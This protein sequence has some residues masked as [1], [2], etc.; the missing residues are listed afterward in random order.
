MFTKVLI[1][2]RGEIACRVIRTCKRMGIRTVAVY[3]DADRRSPH[4]VLADEARHLGP[5]P[6]TASYLDMDKILAV[7]GEAK[8][9]AIHPGYGFLSENETFAQR[10]AEAGFVFIGPPPDVIRNMGNKGVA[11][12]FMRLGGIP[13]VPGVDVEVQDGVQAYEIALSLGFPVMVK[14]ME[15]G[16]GI[17][18]NIA[19]TPDGL[20]AALEAAI[21]RA[22]RAFGRS[23]IYLEKYIAGARHIEVQLL[24]DAY[25]N[26]RHLFDRDCSLQRRYQK[27][28]EEAPSPGVTPE[29]RQRIT[30][31][32]VQIGRLAAY[33][34]AG[35]IE[36]LMDRDK[37]YY[38]L[39]MNTRLQVE[40]PVTEGITGVDIVEQQ[41]RVAAGEALSF[42]QKDVKLSGH[43]IECRIYA[44]N[45]RD[46]LPSPGTIVRL[47]EPSG[48]GVRVDSGV[49]EGS[50]VTI[51]YDAMLAKLITWG[52]TRDSALATMRGALDAY[53]IEGVE[54]NIPLLRAVLRH[55]DF[56]A[57]AYDTT[58]LGQF[59]AQPVRS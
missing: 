28:I 20:K 3:S 40:H 5:P 2:N 43:A 42:Q 39:E 37:S 50:E 47:V 41:L 12:R 34:N 33:Q 21:T 55:P 52:P 29:I 38:F 19:R 23:R 13:I 10:C 35:T 49:A 58:F 36:F 14:A 1:A 15:G 59:R 4:V 46:F 54:T 51:Y 30:E 27:V 22:R 8:V 57:G 18:V 31:A 26:V 56:I 6:A 24:A 16:G 44:E 48:E 9:D 25:G 11:R 7:A 45:P 53:V 32:G 17:G